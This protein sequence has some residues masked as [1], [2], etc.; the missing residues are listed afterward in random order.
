MGLAKSSRLR[1]HG[2][3]G[4]LVLGA[5]L[6]V[7]SVL[8]PARVRAQQTAGYTVVDLG[9]LGGSESRAFAINEQGHV[10]GWS[11]TA[12]GQQHAFASGDD[13]LADLGAL[14]GDVE[15]GAFAINDAGLVAG[16]SARV[17]GANAAV[18]W[19]TD[20]PVN[21][22]RVGMCNCPEYLAAYG[23]NA[24]GTVVGESLR[25]HVDDAA[26]AWQ[27]GTLKPL[28]STMTGANSG[29]FGVNDD[30]DVTGFAG[31]QPAVWADGGLLLLG[32]LGGG[33]GTAR[34][35]NAWRGVV[36][37]SATDPQ[38]PGATHAF[39]WDATSGMSNLGTLGGVSSTANAINGTFIVGESL[40]A[41]GETHAFLYDLNGTGAPLDLNETLA[42]DSGWT[43][44]SATGINSSG[45]I[46]GYGT[47]AGQTHAFVLIPTVIR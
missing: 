46:A 24:A 44:T 16:Y 8:S 14:P 5:L 38:V 41:S 4:L 45:L 34:A 11:T 19:T 20:G 21:L 32:T 36:G 3:S 6:A 2:S 29:A 9:T 43:L 39:F 18:L 37:T 13:G 47:V 23:I 22:G 26:F 31:D 35:I 27:D 15:S 25:L 42:A 28:F 40:T 7:G 33:N 10:A 30:G 17:H 1:W 12:D